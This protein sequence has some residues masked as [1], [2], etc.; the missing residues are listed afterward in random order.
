MA[1]KNI[2]R[3]LKVTKDKGMVFNTPKNLVVDCYAD[4]YFAGLWEN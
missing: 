2:C 4:A 3:Y 1:M